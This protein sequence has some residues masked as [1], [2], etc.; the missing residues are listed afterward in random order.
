MHAGQKGCSRKS[1]GERSDYSFAY[2]ILPIRGPD[3]TAPLMSLPHVN[4]L[5]PIQTYRTLPPTAN[6]LPHPFPLFH[7]QAY[8][9]RRLQA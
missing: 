6:P 7:R 8:L 2:V 9:K 3:Q 4:R 1:R 5:S